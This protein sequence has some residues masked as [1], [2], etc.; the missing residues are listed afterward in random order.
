MR[1]ETHSRTR[2]LIAATA[3]VAVL[4][5]ALAVGSNMGFKANIPISNLSPV[6][7]GDNWISLPLNNP[8]AKA[9]DV[10]TQ[11]GLSAGA[12]VVTRLNPVTGAP[13]S[14][15]CGGPVFLAYALVQGEAIKIRNNNAINGIV[16][17]SHDPTFVYNLVAATPVPKGD[18]WISV[19]YHTTAI[20]A[21][22]LCTDMGLAN[23]AVV[24]RLNAV[25][26]APQSFTCGG[27][28]FLSFSLTIGEGLK[29]RPT[30]NRNWL[31]S[32]F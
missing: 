13:Q 2:W 15:T 27:P 17:G 19:P 16:V 3:T 11:L 21:A 23:G 31:P 29:V 6:P 14:F 12:G 18:N 24:T 9:S 5:G 7:K 22:D 20:K 28:V 10:C 1:T 8:Y 26:G 25:T 30:V 32:H 4:A